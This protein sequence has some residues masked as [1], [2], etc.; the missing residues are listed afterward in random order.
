M[1]GMVDDKRFEMRIS[2]ELLAAI[3]AWAHAQPDRPAR[4]TAIK[5]LIA[6]GIGK[7]SA[8]QKAKPRA[9]K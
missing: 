8:K 5:R 9:R 3:D 7:T 1:L 6:V 4:A 2:E